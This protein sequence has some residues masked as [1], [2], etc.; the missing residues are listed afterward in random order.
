[1]IKVITENNFQEIL[2]SSPVVLVDFWAVWCGPCR[3]LSPTVDEVAEELDG[4]IIVAKCD[5]DDCEQI[6]MKYGIMN[7]PT[8]LFFKNG[9]VA[10]KTVGVVSKSEIITKINNLL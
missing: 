8:L 10:D 4:K 7:I 6:A 1:M 9:E 3:I 2:N 5:V